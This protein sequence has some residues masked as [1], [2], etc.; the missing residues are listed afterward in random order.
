MRSYSLLFLLAPLVL[1]QEPTISGIIVDPSSRPVPDAVV[2]CGSISART[3]ADG[4]FTLTGASACDAVVEASGFDAQHVALEPG[5]DARVSLRIAA[6]NETMV[7]SA[8]RAP[9][10]IEESGASASI[11]TGVDIAARQYPP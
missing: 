5:R 9:I 10:A 1:A 7:V 3:T 6:M 2:H 8:T 11:F 4:R